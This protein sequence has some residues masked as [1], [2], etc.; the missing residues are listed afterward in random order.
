MRLLQLDSS[1]TVTANMIVGALCALGVKP[2]ALEWELSKLDL[3]D[4]HMH[5]ERRKNGKIEGVEFSIHEGATHTHENEK[6][7]NDESDDH[8]ANHD[9]H[10]S[11]GHECCG[12]SH[13]SHDAHVE[14]EHAH[15]HSHENASAKKN[16]AE[17]CEMIAHSDLS[18]FVKKHATTIFQKIVVSEKDNEKSDAEKCENVAAENP[19]S[20]DS[21]A[22]VTCIFAGLEQLNV[23]Q[24][25]A[26]QLRGKDSLTAAILS[27]LTGESS[28]T[29]ESSQVAPEK[30][31]CGFGSENENGRP[32]I[33][34][35]T[36]G[37][38][39]I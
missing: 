17:I 11:Y 23:S 9:H 39:L 6:S 18:D 28:T 2:S 7:A 3:D 37:K 14:H 8:A 16:A 36:L 15:C 31:G 25:S 21:I 29:D 4:F 35:V 34:R 26:P 30:T 12:H 27:E 33:L 13:E 22:C 32:K 10:H 1:E 20:L 24:I 38:A 19:G 5:F